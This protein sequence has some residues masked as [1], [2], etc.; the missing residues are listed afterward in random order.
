MRKPCSA[1]RHSL[2]NARSLGELIDAYQVT[3]SITAEAE[4]EYAGAVF[5]HGLSVPQLALQSETALNWI[6][7]AMS[8]D[9]F[10]FRVP[11]SVAPDHS[12]QRDELPK[13]A[14]LKSSDAI[15][16]LLIGVHDER[17]VF[18]N[19]FIQGWAG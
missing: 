13:F 14:V 4:R 6:T 1:I 18:G 11:R 5:E 17:P 8:T 3:T 15:F 12:R 7:A 19:R 9:A 16:K 2:C 10:A